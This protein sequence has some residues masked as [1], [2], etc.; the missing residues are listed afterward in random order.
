MIID[1][2]YEKD[3][4]TFVYNNNVV[5]IYKKYDKDDSKMKPYKMLI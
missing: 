2:I 5:A 1:N 3:T 4:V